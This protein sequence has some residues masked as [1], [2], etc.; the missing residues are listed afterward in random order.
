MRA[1]FP[2]LLAV[3]ASSAQASPPVD[4]ILRPRPQSYT[5]SC[6][7]YGLAFAAA[8][9]P[10][11]PLQAGTGKQLRVLEVELRKARDAIA[12]AD[13]S[14]PYDHAVWKK[15]LEQV[16]AGAL[17]LDIQ[18]IADF[19]AFVDKVESMTGISN[20]EAL[21]PTLAAA[22]VKLPVLTS[23][24][25]IGNDSYATG[26]VVE[27]MGVSRGNTSPPGLA[28]LNPAVKVG[29]SPEKKTCELDDNV[30]DTKYQAFVSVERSYALK[31]FGGK[32]L[33]MVVKK[34]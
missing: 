30:G 28:V 9:I 24:N 4:L 21:G 18:Y 19:E 32:L 31:Q 2:L 11:G 6:Q 27:L 25:R 8:S 23:V 22:L 34:K 29:A 15:A 3:A 5:D 13:G 14:S 1:L 20:A 17:T 10:G 7:S 26:H 12:K 16:S 33:F